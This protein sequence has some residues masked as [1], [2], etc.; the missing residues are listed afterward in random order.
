MIP[1][2]LPRLLKRPR[3]SSN[4]TDTGGSPRITQ[5]AVDCSYRQIRS[6]CEFEITRVV[7]RKRR[8]TASTAL[9]TRS[10]DFASARIGSWQRA[11]TN[12]ALCAALDELAPFAYYQRVRHFQRPNTRGHSFPSVGDAVE[13]LVRVGRLLFFE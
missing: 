4:Q 5:R 1:N 13:N 12:A 10:V 6:H 8:D 9:K 2:Q 11:S 3:S 7:R